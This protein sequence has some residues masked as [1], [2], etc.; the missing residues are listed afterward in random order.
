MS[1]SE[2]KNMKIRCPD[3]SPSVQ[4]DSFCEMDKFTPTV[5]LRKTKRGGKKMKNKP[6]F[7]IGK[8]GISCYL[9]SKYERI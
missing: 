3:A 7:K 6:N 5:S 4:H 9:I 8:I 2:T 1:K